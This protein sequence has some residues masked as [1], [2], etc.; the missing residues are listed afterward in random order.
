MSKLKITVLF[1]SFQLILAAALLGWGHRAGDPVRLDTLYAPTPTLVCLGINAPALIV[2]PFIG[3]LSA[4]PLDHP[5]RSVFSFGFDELLFLSAVVLLWYLVAKWLLRSRERGAGRADQNK[6]SRVGFTIGSL[7]IGLILLYY[8][9]VALWNFSRFNNPIG[10]KAWGALC[11]EKF[12][13]LCDDSYLRELPM[14]IFR[15]WQP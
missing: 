7:L 13:P 4:T 9:S 6:V 12:D 8:G 5:P 1:P 11:R 10:T 2:W 3:R 15:G 14:T